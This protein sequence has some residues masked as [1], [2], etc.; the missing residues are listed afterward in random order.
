MKKFLVALIA[1]MLLLSNI[2]YSTQNPPIIDE[3]L[4]HLDKPYVYATAGPNTFDCSGFVY[5]CYDVIYNIKLKRSAKEQG[6]D[7][8]YDKI[9]T[10]EELKAGDMVFF[11]TN[12]RDG[13]FCDHSGL[14]IGEGNFIH[15]SSAKGKVIISTLEEGYYNEVFSWGRRIKEVKE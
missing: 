10:I 3:A 12:K 1:A 4:L 9:E 11:N 2:A 15:C 6:Y 5:Y 8:D 14:Y 7:E 13:D